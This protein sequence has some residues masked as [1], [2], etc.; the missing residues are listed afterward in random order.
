MTFIKREAVTV[1][2]L[3]CNHPQVNKIWEYG[4]GSVNPTDDTLYVFLCIELKNGEIRQFKD[5]LDGTCEQKAEKFLSELP[6]D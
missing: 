1:H 5:D 3:T 4:G 2:R 6:T